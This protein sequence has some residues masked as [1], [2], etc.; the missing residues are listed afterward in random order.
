MNEISSDPTWT[1]VERSAKIP[2]NLESTHL[3]I[4]T[5]SHAETGDTID[6]L[7]YDNDGGYIDQLEISSFIVG[8]I[9]YLYQIG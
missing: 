2:F 8:D 1:P 4:K 5:D 6:V 7:L 3:Q 9:R